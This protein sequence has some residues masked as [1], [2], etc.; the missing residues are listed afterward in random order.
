VV[1]VQVVVGMAAATKVKVAERR[2]AASVVTDIR[3]G[4]IYDVD[5][6]PTD[7]GFTVSDLA[8]VRLTSVLVRPLLQQS[9]ARD[10]WGD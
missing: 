3:T 6:M 4:E 9:R 8:Q 1:K 2:L 7:L 5:T 10:P